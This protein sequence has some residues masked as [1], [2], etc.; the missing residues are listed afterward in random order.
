[1]RFAL[2]LLLLFAIVGILLATQPENLENE[3]RLALPFIEG[4]WTGP[5]LWMLGGWFGAGLLLGYLASLPGRIG[6]ARRARRVERELNQTEVARTQ[7]VHHLNEADPVVVARPPSGR[8]EADEMQRLADEVARR[9]ETV[10]RDSP[11]PAR[12]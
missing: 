12:P 10:H 1:M 4:Y 8:T 9:T 5:V 2:I 6:A 7:A 3:V 11:P